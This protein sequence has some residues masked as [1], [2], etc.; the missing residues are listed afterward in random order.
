[1]IEGH[2]YSKHIG[3]TL[4][5]VALSTKSK[6]R[7]LFSSISQAIRKGVMSRYEAGP[8]NAAADRGIGLV[9]SQSFPADIYHYKGFFFF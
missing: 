9:L 5:E 8:P 1:M 6:I 3:T 4:K 2:V 7:G